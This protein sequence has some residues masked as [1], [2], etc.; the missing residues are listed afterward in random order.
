MISLSLLGLF[1]TYVCVTTSSPIFIFL[2]FAI[3][4]ITYF[5]LLD[6]EC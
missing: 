3:I 1:F 2:T 4:L 6:K 5:L